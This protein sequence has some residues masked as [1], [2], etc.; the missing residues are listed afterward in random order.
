MKAIRV[1]EFGGPELLKLEEIA[2][3]SPG[4][5][6]VLVEIQAA[7]VNPVDTYI[8]SGTYHLKPPLPYT[9]G[10]DA[11]GIVMATGEG[12]DQIKV[13]DRVYTGGTLTG[14]YADQTLCTE[15]QVHLLPEAVSFSMGAAVNVPY[16]A[17]Y[18]ALFHRAV[19]VPG[20]AVLIHG[21]TGGVGIAAVQLAKSSGM[22]VIGTGGTENGR[23]LVKKQG[24]DHVLDH[25]SATYQ[26]E[27]LDLTDGQGVNIVLEMLANVNLGKDLK[28]LA[29]DGRIVIIGSRGPV[30]IDPRDAMQRR[31][32]ILGMILMNATEPEI[33]Q[34][35]SALG[36]G[37][38]NGIL[39]PVIGKEFPLEEAVAAHEQVMESKA[40]GKIVLIPK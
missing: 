34:I 19:A 1:H 40:F 13:K 20:E 6:Q 11:A 27:V 5:G 32:N 10:M 2:D 23:I 31:A 28:L 29:R 33:A 24:A 38:N 7:G 37:L 8:R 35:H 30:E 9:P 16:A 17:A 12:V 15:Q 39:T 14:S 21:A 3:L 22:T 25:L 18:H 26:E 4:P 36:A